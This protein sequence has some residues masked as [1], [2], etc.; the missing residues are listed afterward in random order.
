MNSLDQAV[1][2]FEARYQ[3]YI[4]EMAEARQRTAHIRVASTFFSQKRPFADDPIH[5]QAL[6]DLRAL[7]DDV[8]SQINDSQKEA[9][10]SLTRVTC[11][12]LGEKKIDQVEYWPLTSL[13][14]L[15]QPWLAGL[16]KTDLEAIY[17]EYCRVNPRSRCL[18]NQREIRQECERLLAR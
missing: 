10:G 14:G 3:Q 1:A 13:E 16:A 6:Q 17:R 11:L 18:P 4:I 15:A 7:A 2:A 5:A 8:T 12:V 9:N